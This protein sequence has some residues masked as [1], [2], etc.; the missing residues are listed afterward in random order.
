MQYAVAVVPNSAPRK[1][2]LRASK[3]AVQEVRGHP[4]CSHLWCKYVENQ[5]EVRIESH[6][7][8][9]CEVMNKCRVDVVIMVS[10]EKCTQL[11]QPGI[12]VVKCGIS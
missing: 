10:K 1:K 12:T 4:R 5:W 2:I 9:V 8:E 6:N 3:C 7:T 11:S